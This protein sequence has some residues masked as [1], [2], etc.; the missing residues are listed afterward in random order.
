MTVK[1]FNIATTRVL[2]QPRLEPK[3]NYVRY[4]A[5]L[6]GRVELS[7]NFQHKTVAPDIITASISLVVLTEDQLAVF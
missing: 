6:V 4:D 3:E 1:W 7:R 2:A 5:L